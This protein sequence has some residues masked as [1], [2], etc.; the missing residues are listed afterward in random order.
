MILQL[1]LLL[2]TTG[3]LPLSRS[4]SIAYLQRLV[5]GLLLLQLEGG[6][7]PLGLHSAD[8]ISLRWLLSFTYHVALI[9][10]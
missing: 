1:C 9:P 8:L 10:R 3:L 2:A 7:L 6:F 4:I 5:R